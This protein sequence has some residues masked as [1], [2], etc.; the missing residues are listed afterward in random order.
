MLWENFLLTLEIWGNRKCKQISAEML[1]RSSKVQFLIWLGFLKYHQ[2]LLYVIQQIRMMDNIH[3]VDPYT[4]WI[5]LLHMNY[6]FEVSS[7]KTFIDGS[8]LVFV[9][10]I[11]SWKA[12]SMSFWIKCFVS[13]LFWA[14][15]KLFQN[16]IDAKWHVGSILKRV[17][18]SHKTAQPSK[19]GQEAGPRGTAGIVLQLV[20]GP[21]GCRRWWARRSD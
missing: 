20:S 19:I 11:F 21:H 18:G 8:H 1:I 17:P 6:F 3:L 16:I 7:Q 14:I 13:E 12:S 15:Y 4:V 9:R 5:L 10:A 2:M